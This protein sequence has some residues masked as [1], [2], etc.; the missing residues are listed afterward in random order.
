MK[1]RSVSVQLQDNNSQTPAPAPSPVSVVLTSS[2]TAVAEIPDSII[3]IPA[4][5][6]Y[7]TLTIT[8]GGTPGTAN[9]TASAQG[10]LKGSANVVAALSADLEPNMLAVS[11][12]PSTLLPD[13]STY[14]GAVVVS[15]EHV[16]ALGHVSPTVSSNDVTVYARSSNNATMQV[17]T[18][19]GVIPSGESHVAFSISTTFLPGQALITAQSV[20]IAPY[21][22]NLVSVGLSANALKLNFSPQ[23]L[24]SDGGTY[25]SV[26]VSLIDLIQALRQGHR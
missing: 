15:L 5:T 12:A 18:L 19:P 9:I 23:V 14:S 7:A 11:F 3:T 10:Y 2:N 24:L 16:D 26:F 1:L 22:K 8:G 25:D 17:S 4:G 21:T 20:G 13:N 6:S